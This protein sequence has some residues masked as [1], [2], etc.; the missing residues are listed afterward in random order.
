MRT[1]VFI[2]TNNPSAKQSYPEACYE[3]GSF[4]DVLSRARDLIHR[5]H[6][7]VTHPMTGSV[8]PRETKYKSI[9]M[10]VNPE[11]LHMQSLRMIEDAIATARKFRER[12]R[13]WPD[14]ERIDRDFQAID[15]SL[16]AAGV[17]ALNPSLHELVAWER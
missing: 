1:K 15:L 10:T 5:G 3:E 2:L 6:R 13:N 7:L 17:E 14:P 11:V 8:K 4:D 12:E 9:I 16:L